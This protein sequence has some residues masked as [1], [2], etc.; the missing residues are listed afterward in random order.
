MLDK[1]VITDDADVLALIFAL[2]KHAFPYASK[3]LPR[4][5]WRAWLH[6]FRDFGVESSRRVQLLR[7]LE[8]NIGLLF[9]LLGLGK[10]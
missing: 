7:G 5:Q 1:V 2:D 3:S 6:T 8:M 9:C 4:G 10:F